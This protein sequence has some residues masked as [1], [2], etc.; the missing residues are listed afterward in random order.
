M[1]RDRHRRP[2]DVVQGDAAAARGALDPD[3]APRREP[4]ILPKR[5]LQLRDAAA[6]RGGA[7]PGEQPA[8]P[9]RGDGHEQKAAHEKARQPGVGARD[10][11]VLR[12]EMD[13]EVEQ[14]RGATGRY[15]Q[16]DGEHHGP[17]L[18]GEALNLLRRF[19]KGNASEFVLTGAAPIPSATYDYYRCDCTWREHN[20]WLRAKG[21]R[22]QKAIHSLRKAS[23]SLIA[24]PFGIEAARQHLGHRDIRTT[25]AHYVDKKKRVEVVIPVSTVT[26]TI[27]S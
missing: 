4:E 21:V 23:G 26:A 24:S 3:H 11:A 9:R 17:H 5:A 6:R 27:A 25:S 20:A 2:R 19:N 8:G 18:G 16:P 7:K 12:D 13:R 1:A 10:H 14:H 15:A 22:Q